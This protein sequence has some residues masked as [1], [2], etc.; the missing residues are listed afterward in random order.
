MSRHPTLWNTPNVIS[1]PVS[2]DGPT[3][4]D[5]PDGPTINPSGREVAPVKRSARRDGKTVS[6]TLGISGPS[7]FGSSASVALTESLA[8][9][10]KTRLGTGGLTLFRQT[11]KRKAT[12]LGRRYWAHTASTLRTND[13][14][15]TSWPTPKAQNVQASGPHDGLTDEQLAERNVHGVPVEAIRRMRERWEA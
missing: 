7:G 2:G 14:G 13:S 8:N 6:Q 15:C 5:S 3:P 1:S 10:L 4:L 12:P 9:K 11:W